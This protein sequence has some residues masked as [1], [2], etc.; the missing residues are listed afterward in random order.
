MQL[1]GLPA[2]NR[3]RVLWIARPVLYHWATEAVADKLGASSVYN[4]GASSVYIMYILTTLK[5]PKHLFEIA[6]YT[7]I[8]TGV[9]L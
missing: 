3:T 7:C 1:Q 2:G 5:F 4:L 8:W 9:P 6:V